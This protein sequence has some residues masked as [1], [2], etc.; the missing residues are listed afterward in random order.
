MIVN[1]TNN[2]NIRGKV[3]AAVIFIL[4]ALFLLTVQLFPADFDSLLG[5]LETQHRKWCDLNRKTLKEEIN[6]KLKDFIDILQEIE[7]S[8]TPTELESIKNEPCYKSKKVAVEIKENNKYDEKTKSFKKLLD[9]I[10]NFQKALLEKGLLNGKEATKLDEIF[11]QLKI[12]QT[13]IE[14]FAADKKTIASY[15]ANI[16]KMKAAGAELSKPSIS[17]ETGFNGDTAG[18]SS[19]YNLAIGAV[20][21]Y[22]SYPNEFR[23]QASSKVQSQDKKMNENVTNLLVN[24]DHYILPWLEIYGFAQRFSDTYMSIQQRYDIGTGFKLECNLPASRQAKDKISEYDSICQSLEDFGKAKLRSLGTDEDRKKLDDNIRDLVQI[25][26]KYKESY[27]KK[28]TSMELSLAFSIFAG[29]EQADLEVMVPEKVNDEIIMNTKKISLEA[30]QRLM[31]SV[32]PKVIFRP[33]EHVTFRGYIYIKYPMNG[34]LYVNGRRDL[35]KD[36]YASLE[37]GMPES[38]KWV[39]KLSFIIEYQWHYDSVPPSIQGDDLI[40]YNLTEP[41]FA[42]DTHQEFVFKLAIKF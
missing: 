42:K 40:V 3:L 2:L 25:A 41:V 26:K 7:K 14:N 30:D 28:Y 31:F 1:K 38:S 20:L 23:F 17:I 10:A 33:L 27:K 22:T 4:P 19:I 36:L 5:N 34:V 15:L 13:K 21:D 6:S 8:K 35:R 29:M 12:V 24:Y 16:K 37:V 11:T 39:N 32:R 18:D 9:C